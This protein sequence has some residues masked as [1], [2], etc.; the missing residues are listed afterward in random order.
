MTNYSLNR[1]PPTD[2]DRK[3][4]TESI[5]LG[6]F[7]EGELQGVITLRP[8]SKHVWRL[9][10]EIIPRKRNQGIASL[11]LPQALEALSYSNPSPSPEAEVLASTATSNLACLRVLEKCGFRQEDPAILGEGVPDEAVVLL[12][13]HL[14]LRLRPKKETPSQ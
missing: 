6:I 3:S 4:G 8:E 2:S 5:A 9:G 10:I 13:L 7:E 1:L 14:R 11:M 12:H